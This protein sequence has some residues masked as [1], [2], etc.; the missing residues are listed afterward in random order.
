MP[1]RPILMVVTLALLLLGCATP[2]RAP[3]AGTNAN[4]ERPAA[5]TG[6]KRI[7]IGISRDLPA[8]R[9]QLARV[10]ANGLPGSRELEQMVHAGLGIA[11][12]R[13]N[14]LPQLGLAVPT[15][16]NGLWKLLPD[17]RMELTWQINPRARWQDGTPFTADDI[18]FTATVAQDPE[19]P[20]FRSL[21]FEAL[22][23]IETPDPMTVRLLWRSPYIF[24]EYLFSGFE[25]LP[26]LPMPKH[27]LE[28]AYLTNKANF[29]QLPYWVDEFIGAGPFKLSSWERGS[30]MVLVASDHYVAG[31]PKIDEVVV[32]IISDAN[33]MLLNIISNAVE[34]PLQGRFSVTEIVQVRDQWRE[35]HVEIVPANSVNLFPQLRVPNPAVIGDVRFRRALLQ[36]LDRPQMA[37][38][39]SLGLS[40]K[41]DTTIVPGTPEYAYLESSVVRYEHDPRLA[42]ETIRGFGYTAGSDGMLRDASGERLTIQ[43]RSDAVDTLSSA[44]LSTVDQWVR[45]GIGAEPNIVPVQQ[46]ADNAARTNFPGFDVTRSAGGLRG[47]Q[48]FHSSQVRTPE[49]R[50]TGSN[51][52]SY[53]NPEYD[54]LLERYLT[55][56]PRDERNRLAGQIVH[57]LTD[58]LLAMPIYYSVTSTMINSRLMNVPAKVPNDASIA[59][60][61]AAWDVQ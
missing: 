30:Q 41:A 37:E 11:D 5:A 9:S 36:A 59:W 46:Q 43:V 44:A 18:T 56:V 25:E 2:P 6:P 28:S 49:N 53:A 7:T 12:E 32:K 51:F 21:A 10:A 19:L 58:Q 50:Y 42:L 34:M 16:E 15:L 22:E 29:A 1:H 13:G 54:A 14:A 3:N 57:H 31:R 45:L 33:T 27:L 39:L 38:A 4:P 35:G 26:L 52:P 20:Q 23:T 60:N 17:G 47:F 61:A 48:S 55:T 8:L 24:A 40:M